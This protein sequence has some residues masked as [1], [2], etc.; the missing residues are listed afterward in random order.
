MKKH[1]LLFT[2]LL[3]AMS[4]GISHAQHTNAL[5]IA[6]DYISQNAAQWQATQEDMRDLVLSSSHVSDHNKATHIYFLQ[7]HAGIEVHNGMALLQRES[8]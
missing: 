5:Q 3:W 4:Y 7:R 8:N 2:L 6:K 1:N